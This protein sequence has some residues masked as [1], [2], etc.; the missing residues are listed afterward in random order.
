MQLLIVSEEDSA[1]R[2]AQERLKE[3]PIIRD[4]LNAAGKAYNAQGVKKIRDRASDIG[5]DAREAWETSQNPWVYRLSSVYD[6]LTA[7]D[8]FAIGVQELR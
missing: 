3:A 2:K 6:T 1:W 4:V 8:E 7:P 5:E